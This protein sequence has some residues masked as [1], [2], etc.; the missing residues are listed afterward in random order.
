MKTKLVSVEK[1]Q[2][3]KISADDLPLANGDYTEEEVKELIIQALLE[4]DTLVTTYGQRDGWVELNN[5]EIDNWF[6]K[7]KKK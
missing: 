5:K 7:N 2:M 1:L 4:V 3:P 6:N